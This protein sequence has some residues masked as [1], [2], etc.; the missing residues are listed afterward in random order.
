MHTNLKKHAKKAGQPP[1]TVI[2]TGQKRQDDCDITIIDYNQDECTVYEHQKDKACLPFLKSTT[3]T[4]ININGIHDVELIKFFGE[5]LQIHPLTL[6]D[7]A[8]TTQ[9]P[10]I[11]EYPEY[12]FIV[13]KMISYN[14]KTRELDTE[15]ISLIVT[16]NT[17]ISFQERAG[18]IFDPLRR[19][20]QNAGSHLR[21]AAADHLAYA[22][23]DTTIDHYFSVLESISNEIEEVETKLLND[24][25]N[26][27]LH[28][29]HKLKNQ[30]IGLRKTVWPMREL[31]NDFI[32]SESAFIQKSTHIYLRDAYDHTIQVID[33]VETFR[34]LIAGMLDIYLS[35][36]SNRM[37]SIMKV[38]TIIATIFIPL[39][40]ITG[41][42]GM[43][44]EHMPELTYPWAYP[45]VLGFMLLVAGGM[46][47]YFKRR[48][49]L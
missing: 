41:L 6:E 43:N 4:W 39:T 28:R 27:I 21:K 34:D 49:W 13:L 33:T 12:L 16:T 40:F 25:D 46:L 31:I 32:R 15:Q 35:N 19:R 30:M 48:R 2:Y 38:L 20:L 22:I 8:N 24:P 3:N 42:Y 29:I 10:K 44:F 26:T 45:A 23:I 1:G 47:A 5:H 9:R 11:E 37:N 36:L 18:D 7:I 14:E 17:V